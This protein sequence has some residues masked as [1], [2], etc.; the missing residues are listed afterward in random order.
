MQCS[1]SPGIRQFVASPHGKEEVPSSPSLLQ[2]T[3][4]L[5]VSFFQVPSSPITEIIPCLSL[6]CSQALFYHLVFTGG[7]RVFLETGWS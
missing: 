3:G 6:Q 4:I 1:H 7:L 5:L 2:I